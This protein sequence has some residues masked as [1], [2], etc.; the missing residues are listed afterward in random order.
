VAEMI[1]L[2]VYLK[3]RGYEPRQVQD[4]IPAPMARL[5][6]SAGPATLRLPHD[7]K[8]AETTRWESVPRLGADQH[9]SPP[10]PSLPDGVPAEANQEGIPERW[11]QTASAAGP[12]ETG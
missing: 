8:E 11:R 2:A 10:S 4:F 12:S 6:R 3:Q 5:L 7:L 9:R 1:E